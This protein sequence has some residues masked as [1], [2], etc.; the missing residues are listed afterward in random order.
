ML[1]GFFPIVVSSLFFLATIIA[2]LFYLDERGVLYYALLFLSASFFILSLVG[3]T[4]RVVRAFVEDYRRHK[5]FLDFL[6]DFF[7]S[8]KLAIFL[9]VSIGVLS[10]LGSTY[11]QQNQPLGFYLDKFGVDVGLWFW[12]LWLTDVFHSWY[13]MLLIVLLAVNLIV[14][15]VKRLPRVW[16]QTFT[17]ERFQRLDQHTQKHLKPISIKTN[18]SKDKVIAFLKKMGFKVYTEEE[19]GKVYFYGEKGRY[20]RLGVYVVHIGLLVIMAGALIDAVWG[21][22]G[23]VI[24][25]EGSRSDTLVIPSKEVGL[26]LPFQIELENF[27]IVTYGEEARKRGK[28]ISTPF[29]DDV[30]SFESDIRIIKDGKV[31]AEGMTAVNSPFDFGTYRIFQATY[32]LTGEAGTVRLVIFDKEKAVKDPKSALVGEVV[33]KA[34]KVAEF[35]DM[36][37]SIDRSTL[38]IENEQAGMNGD[39]KPAIVVKVLLNHKAYDVPVVYSPELTLIAYNQMKELKDFPYV[40]FMSDFRP[41]FFS[42]FQVSR[43]PGTPIVWLGS[44]LVVGGMILAFYTIHRKVWMR[45]EG[46]TLWVAF[47][48]HKLKEDFKR[49]FIKALEELKHEGASDGKESYAA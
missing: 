19:D 13:Y 33:L 27:R 29:K 30:A 5:S 20:S 8:L 35:K 26:K 6:Y 40:F 1:K 14:C 32:G 3:P 49:S 16:V 37:L 15:S 18:S 24:V 12:K 46:D 31:V 34:G 21:V 17:K 42:G 11:I 4:I 48:S 38:N 44:I 10:M 23:S 2:G 36:L 28:K 9:M 22:R 39:L 47:W 7:S 25:P 43:Q 41:R 45:L